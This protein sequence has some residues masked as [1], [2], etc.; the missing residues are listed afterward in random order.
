MGLRRTSES[1]GQLS[2]PLQWSLF[3]RSLTL[4]ASWN[5]Q[6]M[7]NLGLL[8]SVLA[9]LLTRP[10]EVNRDRIFCRRY[11]G[12]FNTNP[13]LA[14]FLI[15]GLVRLQDEQAAGREMPPH[16]AGTFRDSVG[17]ALASLGDQL[18]WLGLRP[19]I[20]LVI[21]LAGLLGQISSILAVV[22]IF[23][24]GQLL[25]RWISLRVGYD[26][27]LDI[28]DLLLD[29]RWHIWINRTKR[30]GMILTGVVAG[31]YLSQV[32]ASGAGSEKSLLWIGT[33]LGMGLPVV[34]RKRL[35]GEILVLAALALALLL[36][37][38]ISAL[39]S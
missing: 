35:P 7:Q 28:A 37:F 3:V 24:L 36:T 6:R 33:A 13:Y 5:Q 39:G 4:Q 34:L 1:G 15:G 20:V 26:L 11:F 17:R 12:F 19:T 29:R 2:L 32:A 10:R 25:V 27:G 21:C 18:F 22:G 23:A 14:N 31:L 9:W 30:I 8:Y 38:A 16:M